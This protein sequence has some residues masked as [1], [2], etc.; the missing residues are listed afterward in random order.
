[1]KAALLLLLGAAL[2]AAGP[3][4]AAG[5]QTSGGRAMTGEVHRVESLRPWR[6]VVEDIEYAITEHNF[7]ITGRNTI[8]AALRERGY[9]D[10]PDA[11][12]IHFCN[13][14]NAR[15]V[16]LVDADFLALMPCRVAL[17]QDGAR[18][19]VQ[20]VLLPESTGDARVDAFSR[21]LNALL[22]D[23]AE[24]ARD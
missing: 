11:E 16:L 5:L 24:H 19:I 17:H 7:R 21:R 10:A 9:A 2:G 6:D 4:P 12:I 18:V 3:A 22:R 15:E 1:M 23:I 20:M 13:L 14:E 8:G